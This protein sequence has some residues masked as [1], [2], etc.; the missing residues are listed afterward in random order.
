MSDDAIVSR[1]HNVK[2]DPLE[3]DGMSDDIDTFTFTGLAPGIVDVQIYDV[4]AWVEGD[5]EVDTMRL[6]VDDEMNVTR[7]DTVLVERFELRE[8]G[9]RAGCK[10]YA[11]ELSGPYLMTVSSYW[12]TY[13]GKRVDERAINYT[14]REVWGAFIDNKVL[15]WDGFDEYDSDALDG[16]DFSFEAELSDGSKIA[17][18]GSNAFPKGYQDFKQAI[19]KLVG[20]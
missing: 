17:A 9:S 12:D 20:E 4:L 5:Q 10:V 18:H 6:V 13:D 11:G 3:G 7:V 1:T 8:S 15:A 16:Y 14:P 19:G 2:H